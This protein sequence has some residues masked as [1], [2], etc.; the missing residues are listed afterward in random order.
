MC[1][2]DCIV[3]LETGK[4]IPDYSEQTGPASWTGVGPEQSPRPLYTEG[5]SVCFKILL[6]LY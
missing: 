5:T 2:H 1:A 3:L 6:L 4:I